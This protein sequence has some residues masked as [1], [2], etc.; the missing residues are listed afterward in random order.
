MPQSFLH[1]LPRSTD[2]QTVISKIKAD[3]GWLRDPETL[4]GG[5]VK[6][7]E[8]RDF[9]VSVQK[10]PLDDVGINLVII[11]AELVSS[12]VANTMLKILE[13]PPPYLSFH[14][15]T[16]NP[17]RVLPTILSRCHRVH[18]AGEQVGVIASNESNKL[19]DELQ[20][21]KQ[22]T[23]DEGLESYLLDKERQAIVERRWGRAREIDKILNQ[24]GTTN[25]NIS[26]ALERIAIAQK[27]D[28]T[29][30]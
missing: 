12:D 7:K 8:M 20:N 16:H 30:K 19:F 5:E 22:V 11:N 23:K 10:K 25:V 28:T 27:V 2:Q 24:F 21:I 29:Q 9:I 18:H 26:L 6:V 14:L 15:I 13:E 17:H 3:N 1:I 4:N